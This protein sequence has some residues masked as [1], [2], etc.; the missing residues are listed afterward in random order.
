[1][2][3]E[4][5]RQQQRQKP[6]RIVVC[7]LVLG[8]YVAERDFDTQQDCRVGQILPMRRQHCKGILRRVE[9]RQDAPKVLIA[10]HCKP[11]VDVQ[12]FPHRPLSARG[13]RNKRGRQ[14]GSRRGVASAAFAD[15][16]RVEMRHP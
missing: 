1:M 9:Q 2:T 13:N 12:N 11:E 14:R 10:T 15:P 8:Q 6:G 4:H 16:V 5:L 3:E 7:L